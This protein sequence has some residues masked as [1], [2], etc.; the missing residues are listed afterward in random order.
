M[1]R[2]FSR[3]LCAVALAGLSASASAVP[4]YFNFTGTV[5]QADGSFAQSG[6]EGAAVSGGFV[7][8]TE[9]LTRMLSPDLGM[10]QYFDESMSG[11]NAFL[12]IGTRSIAFPYYPQGHINNIVF[13]DTVCND[14]V[15]HCSPADF[16]RFHLVASSLDD[17]FATVSSPD[18]I[19]THRR[20]H[21]GVMAYDWRVANYFDWSTVGPVDI[22]SLPF[23]S[24]GG[25]YSESTYVCPGDTFCTSSGG[26]ISFTIDSVTRGFGPA[27]S[28]PEPGALGLLGA[29]GLGLLLFGRRHRKA[30]AASSAC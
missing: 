14:V 11:S 3:A 21:L 24:I 27:T 28:V 22:V 10:V 4:I 1:K 18:Y 13:A 16:E 9:S 20:A 19:G 23:E 2:I 26:G 5:N 15:F 29:A 30:S 8:Q 6:L 12:N 7:F 17:D 25:Y